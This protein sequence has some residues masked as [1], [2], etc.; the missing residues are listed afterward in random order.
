MIVSYEGGA[1]AIETADYACREA[2]IEEREQRLDTLI[3]E[4]YGLT[5]DEIA[6]VENAGQP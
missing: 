6:I 3:Y 4:L 1:E 5:P 2:M